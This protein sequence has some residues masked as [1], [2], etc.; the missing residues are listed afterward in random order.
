MCAKI[1][2]FEAPV[3]PILKSLQSDHELFKNFGYQMLCQKM[4]I[5][6]DGKN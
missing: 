3:V 6:K 1:G 2:K 5:D 4:N